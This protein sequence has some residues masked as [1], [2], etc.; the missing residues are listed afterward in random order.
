MANFKSLKNTFNRVY[1]DGVL[2]IY[3]TI[4]L[5]SH[6]LYWSSYTNGGLLPLN[7]EE[8]YVAFST[9]DGVSTAR[10]TRIHYFCYTSHFLW[11]GY[12]WVRQWDSD[13]P[14]QLY[15]SD[16]GRRAS[17]CYNRI[18]YMWFVQYGSL[19]ATSALVYYWNPNKTIKSWE[20]WT[21]SVPYN[22]YNCVTIYWGGWLHVIGGGSSEYHLRHYYGDGYSDWKQAS[23]LPKDLFNP[24]STIDHKR[25]QAVIWEHK[26]IV[27]LIGYCRSENIIYDLVYEN[28]LFNDP[29]LKTITSTG[30]NATNCWPKGVFEN[31]T[32]VMFMY[33]ETVMYRYDDGTDSWSIAE[34]NYIGHYT[35]DSI[36]LLNDKSLTDG[37]VYRLQNNYRHL[38]SE[39]YKIEFGDYG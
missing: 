14:S 6:K 19:A 36:V 10:K 16:T 17:I 18:G 34:S 30:L 3:K 27:H 37:N 31:A 20:K 8:G 2:S 23:D 25:M 11:T 9:G 33:T 24:S 7:K 4:K 35:N 38:M 26:D 1:V 5:K 21:K 29:T 22:P 32:G 39:A 28:G 13:L 12:M 15:S